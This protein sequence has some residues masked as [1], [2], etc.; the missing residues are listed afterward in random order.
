MLE[1]GILVHMANE[2]KQKTKHAYIDETKIPD[3]GGD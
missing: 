1:I 3:Y 2:T